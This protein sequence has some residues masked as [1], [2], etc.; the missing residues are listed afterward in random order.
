MIRKIKKKKKLKNEDEYDIE[1]IKKVL[2]IF[3]VLDKITTKH[4]KITTKHVTNNNKTC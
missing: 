3:A 2:P 4:V 1:I